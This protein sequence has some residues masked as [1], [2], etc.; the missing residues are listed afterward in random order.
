MTTT[1]ESLVGR[2]WA[3]EPR[4]HNAQSLALIR[5]MT[6]GGDSTIVIPERVAPSA[7]DP[8]ASW[9]DSRGQRHFGWNVAQTKTGKV[10]IIPIMGA[11]SRYGDLCA[12]GTEDISS[13]ILEAN[14]LDE[15]TSIVLQIDSP[16]GDVNGTELLGDIVRTSQKPVVAYVQGMAASAAYWVASQAREI[17][18][19]SETSTEVGSIGVL[20]VHVDASAFYE[21]E[22]IKVT[23]IRSEGS[24]D[25]ALFNDIEGLSE[26]LKA[27]VKAQLAPIKAQFIK[28]VKSGRPNIGEVFT[29]KMYNGKAALQLGMADRIGYLGDAVY[30]ADLLARKQTNN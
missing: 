5:K 8:K 2:V 27:D 12:Y 3:L 28:T 22:G 4:F 30:R 23:I 1:I 20:A 17:I 14:A 18:M 21:K 19:E 9:I 24:D 26:E 29:G 7:V 15:I 11:M 6:K 13:F 25:K 16:G 10:A